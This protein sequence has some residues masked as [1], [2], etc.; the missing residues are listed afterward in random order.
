MNYFTELKKSMEFL[1]KKKDTIFIGQAV[2]YPGTAIFNTLKDIDKKKKIEFPVAEEMQM[3]ATLGIAMDG[4]VPI[5]IFPRWNFLI[6]GINQLVNHI[7]KI[8][9]MGRGKFK[10]KLIIR[11]AIGSVR[12]LNPQSQHIGDFTK[13]ISSMCKNIDF[14]LLEESADIFKSYHKAYYRDDKKPTVLIEYGDFYNE[15]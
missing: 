9:E 3:G 2:Q 8:K 10:Q 11:T 1:A 15:K 5:S 7:D 4:N 6:L 12:P 13:E 14:I